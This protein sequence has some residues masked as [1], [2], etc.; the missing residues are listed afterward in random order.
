MHNKLLVVVGLLAIFLALGIVNAAS[1][2]IANT[3]LTIIGVPPGSV[4]PFRFAPNYTTQDFIAQGYTSTFN[5]YISNSTRTTYTSNVPFQ[6]QGSGTALVENGVTYQMFTTNTPCANQI[7]AVGKNN[8]C[9]FYVYLNSS[10]WNTNE[11][12]ELLASNSSLNHAEIVVKSV[13]NQ[14][15]QT[16]YNGSMGAGNIIKKASDH[17]GTITFLKN[18]VI[19]AMPAC[20]YINLASTPFCA[21]ATTPARIS[22]PVING[23]YGLGGGTTYPLTITF[24]A[25]LYGGQQ[26]PFNYSVVDLTNGTALIP[27]TTLTTNDLNVVQSYN[28]PVTQ[29][30]EITAGSG[31]NA[32]Y[33]KQYIDPVTMPTN[34]LEY[35]PVTLTNSQSTGIPNPFQQMITV[36]S[37]AYQSYEASNLQNIE[38]FYAN[39]TIVPSWLES[40]N[41]NADTNT[42]YWLR[43]PGNFLPASSSNTLYLGF[44]STSTTLFDGV[45]VGEAAPLSTT[46]GQYDNGQNVFDIYGDFQNTL[47]SWTAHIYAGTFTPTAT[48]SGV[49]LTNSVSAEGAYI[50]P[51]NQNSLPVVPI[52]LELS[53][54]HTSG[55]DA[56]VPSLFGESS[57]MIAA[58]SVGATDGGESPAM[59]NSV[60]T[61]YEFYS[62]QPDMWIKDSIPGSDKI[63]STTT[64]TSTAGTYFSYF[65]IQTGM[66]TASSGFLSA[67]IPITAFDDIANVPAAQTGTGTVP[68]ASGKNFTV[69]SGTG[70]ASS[71]AYLQWLVGRSY[72][73]NGILPGTTYG[74]VQFPSGVSCTT[75]ITSPSNA[76]VDVGQYESFTAS[77]S[78]CV[79]SFTYNM[80]AVNS[81]TTSIIT[82]NSLISGATATSEAFTFQTVSADTSN[83]P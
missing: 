77:E 34:I 68:V 24:K 79:S 66:T 57:N 21:N 43:L 6:W 23:H 56:F 73:P 14:S 10:L 3:T 30:I 71:T 62:G 69:G 38:F 44:A 33:S 20:I 55:A 22:V 74:T 45:T 80:L 4:L 19:K 67:N 31:G 58:D 35:V 11:S 17:N 75:S 2:T 40:G 39:G 26:A 42:I 7:L 52:I 48:T 61:Q 64:F 81:I 82:H 46:Y 12:A 65:E 53:W 50:S 29:Q 13:Q 72:P 83:S 59:S 1:N 78:N 16:P 27:L 25:S 54:S 15:I 60:Y 18:S 70:G 37:L 76:I 41:S 32:N 8:I 63:D 36:N 47:D 49:Q 9:A 5:I 51:P 28:I